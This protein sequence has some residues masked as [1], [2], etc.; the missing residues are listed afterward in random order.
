[1]LWEHMAGT[2]HRTPTERQRLEKA[3]GDVWEEFFFSQ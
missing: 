2:L 3:D 1:M